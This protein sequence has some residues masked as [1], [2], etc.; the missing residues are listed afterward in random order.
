MLPTNP[1]VVLLV[2]LAVVLLWLPV[3][4]Y[5]IR[6]Y[7]QYRKPVSIALALAC[8]GW[9][10]AGLNSSFHNEVLGWSLRTVAILN[11]VFMVVTILRVE[12]TGK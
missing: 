1:T 10:A 9:V 11:G 8:L 12:R 2:D 6:R 4:G 3:V 7:A 5:F